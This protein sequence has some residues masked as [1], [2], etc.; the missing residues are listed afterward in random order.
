MTHNF[1]TEDEAGAL[2]DQYMAD[3]RASRSTQALLR[4]SSAARRLGNFA[5]RFGKVSDSIHG[6]AGTFVVNRDM[7]DTDFAPYMT[8]LQYT[9]A[10]FTAVDN[11]KEIPKVR[12][13]YKNPPLTTQK[14]IPLRL[15][16]RTDRISTH[17]INRGE[18]PFKDQILA[19]N[20]HAMRRLTQDT[21]GTSQ[22]DVN[23]LSDTSVVIAAEN[24]QTLPI[25]MVLRA[26]MVKSTT[27]TSL[28]QA[29]LRKDVNFCGHFVDNHWIPNG[30]LPYVMDTPST[31]SD[32]HDQ[33]VAPEFFFEH[34]FCQPD[35][36]YQMRN[37]ALVAFGVVSQF[38]RDKGLILADT[39]TEHGLT[40]DLCIV[41]QD[42]LYTLDSSRFW[43]IED[44]TQQLEQL[45]RGEIKEL[46]PLSFSK[47][48]ARGFSQGD[49]G[50]SDE[51]RRAIAVRYIMGI[52]HL[53]GEPFKPDLRSR[54]E[55]VVSGLQT[56]VE[57]L[58]T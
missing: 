14:G 7:W 35:S 46:N 4:D 49:Q 11:G 23:G 8:G 40:K 22:F 1:L 58:V 56:I 5:V 44:Y 13:T 38:V 20:H 17:D 54:E 15:M 34:G 16:V 55:R 28:Y 21:L 57:Q 43:K 39:K 27:A 45:A 19:V 42:E 53:T 18:I 9:A 3:E 2:V 25:E 41:A 48:F 31:K 37:A 52:Q 26:Y 47:E 51:Q 10:H 12:V 6:G 33:S 32:H 30:R 24:L 36:Y 29:W 50:Y